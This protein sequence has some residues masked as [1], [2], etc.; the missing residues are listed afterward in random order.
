M[1]GQLAHWLL[2][3]FSLLIR[4][5][6]AMTLTGQALSDGHLND[7][8][9][10][11]QTGGQGSGGNSKVHS[12]H[13]PWSTSEM[14]PEF[15]CKLVFRMFR[16]FSPTLLGRARF[17]SCPPVGHLPFTSLGHCSDQVADPRPEPM[18]VHEM[19]RPTFTGACR[20]WQR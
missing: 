17:Q 18:L 13:A 19:G 4:A 5:A 10:K 14:G 9:L 6:V 12:R 15:L 20:H 3:L 11:T 16:I 1:K 2:L 8:H 7:A